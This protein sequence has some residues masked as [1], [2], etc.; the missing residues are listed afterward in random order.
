M[1]MQSF[2]DRILIMFL[3]V[4][5]IAGCTKDQ[6]ATS[7][8]TDARQTQASNDK[9][10]VDGYLAKWDSFAQGDNQLVPFLRDNKPTFEVALTQLL[11]SGDRGA[12]ARVVFYSV[13]QVG[14][15]IPVESG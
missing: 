2:S 7:T 15:S 11:K 1:K 8:T 3:L 10:V 13:V 14:G 12:P 4:N 5:G 9:A 6:S